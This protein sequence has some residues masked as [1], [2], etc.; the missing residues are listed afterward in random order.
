MSGRG[1]VKDLWAGLA[2]APPSGHSPAWMSNADLEE[3]LAR[4][5]DPRT[6]VIEAWRY[7]R[8]SQKSLPEKSPVTLMDERSSHQSTIE[9]S[10]GVFIRPLSELLA[11]PLTHLEELTRDWVISTLAHIDPLSDLHALY[12]KEGEVLIVPAG[13]RDAKVRIRRE[14]PCGVEQR[15]ISTASL[16]VYQEAESTLS[17]EESFEG[18]SEQNDQAPSVI[19]GD[20]GGITIA[21]THVLLNENAELRHVRAQLETQYS[22]EAQSQGVNRLHLGR[23]SSEV[24]ERASYTLSTLNLGANIARLELDIALR[25]TRA[26]ADLAGVYVGSSR[27][28]L[29][30]HLTLR[31]LQPDC[32]S[33]QRFRGVLGG[34]SRGV[35]TG[36]VIVS[37]G[38]HSTQ[39]EQNNPNLL[40]SQGARAVTRPQ[41][42]IYNDDVEC[43]HGATVGQLNEDALF[44]LRSRGLSE[45]AALR[46]LTMAFVSE[47]R[48]QL[49]NEHLSHALDKSLARALAISEEDQ[50]VS[51]AWFDWEQIV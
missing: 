6:P 35:F 11:S 46:A 24:R 20:K 16:W 42:E 22:Q 33:S 48:Q 37:E 23:V 38:A 7:T 27:A 3:R 8:L 15:A 43:S 12:M 36:R 4:L 19:R 39:A 45:A 50:D 44:Y 1:Q 28:V 5:R 26:K 30:Q 10:G 51:E 31:H 17:L 49:K 2:V 40:V 32:H 29:D 13:E 14:I 41:L 47:I 34:Q 18:V 9:T 21:I 25:G